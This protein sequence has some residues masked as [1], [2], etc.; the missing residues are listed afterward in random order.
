MCGKMRVRDLFLSV[1]PERPE[2]LWTEPPPPAEQTGEYQKA[3]R[4]RE[5]ACNDALEGKFMA[6]APAGGRGRRRQRGR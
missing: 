4:G 6:D 3:Q 2:T 5:A 1:L